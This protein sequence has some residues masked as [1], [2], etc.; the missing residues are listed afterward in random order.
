VPTKSDKPFL[1]AHWNHLAVAPVGEPFVPLNNSEEEFITEHYWGYTA[2]R[3]GSSAE[4]RV[5]HPSWRVWSVES[6]ELDC[7]VAALYGTQF[8]DS[9]SCKPS[10][11]LLAEGSAV[12]VYR[13]R[14]LR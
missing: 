4:Y 11:S 5:E 12:K 7:D 10:S 8:V 2:H 9:L 1:T 6:A 3:D 13:G 14:R